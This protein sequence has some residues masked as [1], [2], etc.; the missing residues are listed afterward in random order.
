MQLFIHR[1]RT[2]C[3]PA[4]FYHREPWLG[5]VQNDTTQMDN[6]ARPLQGG[7]HNS[8]QSFEWLPADP[9]VLSPGHI[10]E[11]GLE[12]G[13]YFLQYGMQIISKEGHRTE[14]QRQTDLPAVMPHVPEI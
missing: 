14:E 2:R 5:K 8:A 6:A 12:N 10:P 1:Q 4:D 7:M 13:T 9:A 3:S 11:A